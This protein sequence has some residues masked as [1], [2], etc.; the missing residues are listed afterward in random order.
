MWIFISHFMIWPTLKSWFIIEVA[1]PLTVLVCL[2]VWWVAT[3]GSRLVRERIVQSVQS[4]PV[5]ARSGP[6]IPLA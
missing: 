6:A 3:N 4:R 2:G 1:Y 5:G